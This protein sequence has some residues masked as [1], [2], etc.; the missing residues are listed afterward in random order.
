MTGAC[1]V[2]EP[3]DLA[4][5]LPNEVIRSIDGRETLR[6]HGEPAMPVWGEVFAGE[7]GE[8]TDRQEIA[9]AEQRG[10][11]CR[12]HRLAPAEPDRAAEPRRLRARE[13][14]DRPGV[15]HGLQ[16]GLHADSV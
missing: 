16:S 12:P 9:R 4:S 7:E 15:Q 14:R 13:S 10:W 5:R 6:A 3:P 1:V 11:V 8:S 2:P